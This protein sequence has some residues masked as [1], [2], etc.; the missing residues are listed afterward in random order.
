MVSRDGVGTQGLVGTH[1]EPG[2]GAVAWDPSRTGE[3]LRAPR[4]DDHKYRR[5]VLGVR[6]GAA[7]YPGAAVLGVSGA[8]RTGLG[9]VRYVPP[10]GESAE[11]GLPSAAAAVLAAR[12]ETVFGEPTGRPCDAWLIG[13]GTDSEARPDAETEAIRSLLMGDAPVVADAGAL[14]V[15]VETLMSRPPSPVP[16]ILTPHEGEF[17]QLWHDSGLESAPTLT[18]VSGRAKAAARLATRL[19][20]TVLLKGSTTVVAGPRVPGGEQAPVFTVGPATPWLA[21]AGTGDVLGGVLGALVAAH[22][23]RV[24]RDPSLLSAL[25]AAAAHLHD[26]AARIAV[27]DPERPIT[28][29]DVADALP[30]A[31]AALRTR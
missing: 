28:A 15:A 9:M 18:G 2:P 14:D 5:G 25:G 20:A 8:W 30:A 16:V 1:G 6:T 24:R 4:P 7:A 17:G 10:I 12:P 31:V 27:G 23:E 19:G 11:F 29:M 3:L 13:S 22:A 21:T 26:A